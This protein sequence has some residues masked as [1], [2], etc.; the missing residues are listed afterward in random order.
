M[1]RLLRITL[2]AT[3]LVATWPPEVSADENQDLDLIPSEIRDQPAKPITTA[4][5]GEPAPKRLHAKPFI[6]DALALA[7]PARTVPVPYPLPL[8]DWQNR[9]SFDLYLQWTPWRPLTITIS[10]RLNLIEQDNLSFWSRHTVRNDLREAYLSWEVAT[11][12]FLEAGRINIRNGTALGYNPTDFFRARTLVG[13][14]S[15]DPST[16]RQNR[17]GTLMARAQKIW[18]G[19]SASIAFAPKV[20]HASRIFDDSRIGIDPSF[21][22]TNAAYRGLATLSL[23]VGAWSPQLL[24]YY[25]R[26]RSKLGLGVSRAFGDAVVAYAEWAGGKESNLI[27]RSFA[28]AQTTEGL[29]PDAPLPLPTDTGSAFRNDLAAGASWTI[30]SKVTLNLEYHFH[31]AGFTRQDWQDWFDVGSSAASPPALA[32]QLWYIRGYAADQQEPN[33]RHQVFLRVAWPRAILSHLDLA[34]FALVDLYAGSTLAQLAASYYL[35]D[36][37]T[38]AVY[39]AMNAGP[40]RSERGS[41]PRFGSVILQVVAYL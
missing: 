28:Y 19:G 2:L 23:D 35:S 32:D 37:W 24:G 40:A 9:T 17:L 1:S 33:S 7:G 8:S 10:N 21:D 26:D 3:A 13:Q 22:T 20:A 14:A 25:E 41:L 15:L 16:I 29:P 39:G 31:Q 11:N 12:T 27:A 6:E 38:F 30:G 4:P 34:G 5:P 18:A 36:V